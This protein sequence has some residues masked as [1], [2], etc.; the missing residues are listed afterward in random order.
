LGSKKDL[1]PLTEIHLLLASR[2]E[3]LQEE[4]LPRL[5]NPKNF[6]ILDRYMHSTLA[7]QGHGRSLGAEMIQ[8]MHSQEPLNTR[9]GLTFYLD[10]DWETSKARLAHREKDY[11]EK[12]SQ[13]FFHAV[14]NGYHQIN[15]QDP[16]HF[17]LINGSASVDKT[18]QLLQNIWS[19]YYNAIQ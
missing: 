12:S 9:P 3:L 14:R 1:H 6:V 13:E 10:I 18:Q 17:K 19:E 15:R 16:E 4:I 5:K 8:Q 7:Y 2:I 11:F